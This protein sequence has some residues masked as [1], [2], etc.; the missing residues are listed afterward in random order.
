MPHLISLTQELA[1]TEAKPRRILAQGP[2]WK[3]LLLDLRNAGELPVHTAPGPITVHCLEGQ[4]DFAINGEW[5]TLHRGDIQTVEA[6][7]PH[8]VKAPQ[9]AVLLVHL[10]A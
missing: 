10:V 8:A 6:N 7:V 5:K 9:S 1:Q 2:G 3:I 4:A